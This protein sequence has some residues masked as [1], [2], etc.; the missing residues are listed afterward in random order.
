MESIRFDRSYNVGQV[1]TV[2]TLVISLGVMIYQQGR[3][4]ATTET[5]LATGEAVRATYLPIVNGVVASTE[6]TNDRLNNIA[7]A[8]AD[9]RTSISGLGSEAGAIRERLVAIETKLEVV[10]PPQK[11][12]FTV[13]PD[14]P[15]Y[16]MR[17]ET[18]APELR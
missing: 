16:P 12:G 6:V 11:L 7:N 1:A 18:N 2:I 5:R 3:F 10:Q 15:Q 13:S 8:M 17:L 4:Q 9:I 14:A